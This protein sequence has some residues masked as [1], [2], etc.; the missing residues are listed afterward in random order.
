LVFSPPEL[1]DVGA[2]RESVVRGA[3]RGELS[4]SDDLVTAR[5]GI[6]RFRTGGIAIAALPLLLGVA[7]LLAGERIPAAE[8][9][10]LSV[11]VLFLVL[12]AT[13]CTEEVVAR[14]QAGRQS[15]D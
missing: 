8:M 7:L 1:H 13:H 6:H 11:I 4:M 10:V 9:I 14:L 3:I 5:S 12:W 2:S 15:R